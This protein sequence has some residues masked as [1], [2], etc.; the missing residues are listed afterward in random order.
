LA[1]VHTVNQRRNVWRI[2]DSGPAGVVAVET[3][4]GREA[5]EDRVYGLK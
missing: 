1:V 2:V 5:L 3:G 4:T